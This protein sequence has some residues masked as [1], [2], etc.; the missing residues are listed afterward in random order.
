MTEIAGV[1]RISAPANVNG[2]CEQ[3]L[4]KRGDAAAYQTF[5]A[6]RTDA[7]CDVELILQEIDMSRRQIDLEPDVGV[8]ARKLGHHRRQNERAKF[9]RSG[10]S[11]RA[12]HAAR[13]RTQGVACFMGGIHQRGTTFEETCT[14]VGHGNHTR[15]PV[16]Q[17]STAVF[18]E[19]SNPPGD[20]SRRYA[21]QRR[22]AAEAAQT[23][24][25]HEQ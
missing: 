13:P 22:S 11:Q 3:A 23:G 14:C 5:V 4:F 7:H 15:G 25:F 1:F 19:C 9:H 17:Q 10:D 20:G 21:Q 6:H 18:L 16:E 24:N 8:Q 2:S 12:G